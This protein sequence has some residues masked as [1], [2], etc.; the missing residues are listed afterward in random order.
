[1]TTD[2]VS[3]FASSLSA[4][5]VGLTRT[6]AD[7]FDE[8]LQAA[9]EPPAVGVELGIDGVSLDEAGVNTDPTNRELQEAETGVTRAGKGIASYGTLVVQSDAAGTEPMA[10]YPPNHVAVLRESDVLEDVGSALAW[11]GE[12]FDAGRDSAVFATGVSATAD[13]GELVFGVHGPVAVH[14]ILVT[15]R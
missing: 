9:V 14:V 1:M 8:T 11:L 3:R 10:L 13:M 5:G 4:V 15:D 12:E 2:T 6:T 7:E